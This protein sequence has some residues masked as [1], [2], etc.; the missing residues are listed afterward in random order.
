MHKL[1]QM[2]YIQILNGYNWLRNLNASYAFCYVNISN[3][4]MTEG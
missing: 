2:K 3:K 4:K 1:Y